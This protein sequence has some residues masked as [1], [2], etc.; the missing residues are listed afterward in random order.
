MQLKYDVKLVME[1]RNDTLLII[2]IINEG[3]K[4]V[5]QLN[6]IFS[7][8]HKNFDVL[9]SDGGSTDGSIETIMQ[10]YSDKNLAILIKA[11]EGGLSTQIRCGIHFA[12]NRNYKYVLTMDGNNKDEVEGIPR[13]IAALK[14]EF[15]FVQGSRFLRKGDAV[16]TPMHRT[17]AI[18]LLHAP[19]ISFAARKRFTDT[20][21]GFRGFSSELLADP[22]IDALRSIFKK[23]EL[24]VYLP[25]VASRLKYRVCE[26]AVKR[27]Y[28]SGGKTPTKVI[29]I[30]N[31]IELIFNLMNA[32]LGRFNVVKKS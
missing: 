8:D 22:Q 11:E 1:K 19:L 24:I 7:L 30:R 29:G 4:I 12:L 2:P 9:I 32:C 6:E 16:N 5:N 31:H 18:K 3:N 27:S 20:T 13:I 14:N 23:Y 17:L 15:D 28:P 26:I 10:R 25:I 21:N